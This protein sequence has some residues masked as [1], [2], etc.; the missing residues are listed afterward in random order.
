MMG[1]LT[2]LRNNN[3]SVQQTLYFHV[4]RAEMVTSLLV[5]FSS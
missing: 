5:A 2:K 1:L 4:K 3:T